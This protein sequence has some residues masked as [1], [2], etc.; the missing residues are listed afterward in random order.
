VAPGSATAPGCDRIITFD[1][2]PWCFTHSP[3]EGSSQIGYSARAK[4]MDKHG[5]A[6]LDAARSDKSEEEIIKTFGIMV[7]QVRA[8]RAILREEDN[9]V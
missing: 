8:L 3:D 1:D 6:V 7:L 4:F 2:E 5:E 9:N